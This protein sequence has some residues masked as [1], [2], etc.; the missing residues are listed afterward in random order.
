MQR[1]IHILKD[2]TIQWPGQKKKIPSMGLQRAT[3]KNNDC[4]TKK[5][6]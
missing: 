6:H 1:K 2:Q 3:Q 5:P 4:A